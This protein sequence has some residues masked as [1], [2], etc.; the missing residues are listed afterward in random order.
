MRV[1]GCDGGSVTKIARVLVGG[2]LKDAGMK[3]EKQ[4]D[5]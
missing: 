4:S 5:S 1:F 2:K 3:S